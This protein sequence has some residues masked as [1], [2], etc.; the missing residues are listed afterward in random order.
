MRSL[1]WFQVGELVQMIVALL[2]VL[3]AV[4]LLGGCS[5]AEMH[6]EEARAAYL[7]MQLE[8]VD[9]YNTREAIDECRNQVRAR[10]LRANQ[11]TEVT[12]KD[13]GGDR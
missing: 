2:G 10:W 8:C 9:R 6:A 7:A 11:I 12:T 1:L 5:P 3:V 4:G 13:A